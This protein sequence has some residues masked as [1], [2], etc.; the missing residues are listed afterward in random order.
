MKRSSIA[1]QTA[2][3]WEEF[4]ETIQAGYRHLYSRERELNAIP[5][6]SWHGAEAKAL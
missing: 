2:E 4:L 3:D 6:H 5:A 1:N